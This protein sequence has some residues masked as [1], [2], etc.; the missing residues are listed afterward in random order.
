MQWEYVVGAMMVIGSFFLVNLAEFWRSDPDDDGGE[1][2]AVG[3]INGSSLAGEG[4]KD[5]LLGARTSL[6]RRGFDNDNDLG[7]IDWNGDEPASNG[8]T[9]HRFEGS[10]GR[11]VA[12]GAAHMGGGRIGAALEIDSSQGVGR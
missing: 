4:E 8:G 6:G 11:D 9:P 10:P 3:R 12:G 1:A 7:D 2:N 5:E